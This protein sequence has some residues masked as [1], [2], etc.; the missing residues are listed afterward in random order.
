[1]TATDARTSW[2]GGPDTAGDVELWVEHE[3][4]ARRPAHCRPRTLPA[5]GAQNDSVGP[6]PIEGS[7]PR[8]AARLIAEWVGE[9]TDELA[10][11]WD[12]ASQGEEP[13]TIEPL[14]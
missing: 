9:H 1:M 5:R 2:T 4:G 6:G 10:A 3:G 8:R 12:K 13:G 7:L 11:C 14:K